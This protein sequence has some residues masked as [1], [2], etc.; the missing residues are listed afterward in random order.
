MRLLDIRTVN[1]SLIKTGYLWSYLNHTFSDIILSEVQLV[2]ND[3]EF[4]V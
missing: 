4:Y 1:E 3:K 2:K